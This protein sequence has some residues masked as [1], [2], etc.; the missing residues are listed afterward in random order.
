MFA[1]QYKEENG[2]VY[3]SKVRQPTTSFLQFS[4]DHQRRLSRENPNMNQKQVVT[5]VGEM[6]NQ[7]PAEAKKVYQ[8]RARV[9]KERFHREYMEETIANG[10]IRKPFASRNKKMF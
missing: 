4:S 3:F 1:K 2:A 10:G 6:W 9:D 8:E 5:L 7:L